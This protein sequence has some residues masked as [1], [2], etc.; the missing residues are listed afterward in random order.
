LSTLTETEAASCFTSKITSSDE[1]LDVT[2]LLQDGIVD[3]LKTGSPPT[4]TT[5][6]FLPSRMSGHTERSTK[7]VRLAR[8]HS[9]A[10]LIVGGAP[11]GMGSSA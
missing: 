3:R 4:T 8:D 11:L 10:T 6:I 7:Q 2:M 5:T 9:T 1:N